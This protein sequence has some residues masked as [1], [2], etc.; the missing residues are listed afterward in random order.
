MSSSYYGVAVLLGSNTF[1]RFIQRSTSS[2]IFHRNICL[3]TIMTAMISR[4]QLCL[5]AIFVLVSSVEGFRNRFTQRDAR[6]RF[7]S[8][9]TGK[10]PLVANG[11]RF[12]A[13]SGSSLIVV[14]GTSHPFFHDVNVIFH[15][16]S[17][18]LGCSKIRS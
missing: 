14:R 11:K 12:E 9:S 7:L 2:A 1:Q 17:L 15:K 4:M 13:D 8:M 10:T 3:L 18:Y 6:S 5:V 16:L